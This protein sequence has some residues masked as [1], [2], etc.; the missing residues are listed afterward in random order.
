MLMHT[1]ALT[2]V[3]IWWLRSYCGIARVLAWVVW[4]LGACGA[5]ADFAVLVE[6]SFMGAL[7]C[8]VLCWTA[9]D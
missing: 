2:G 5:D 7:H 3:S 8:W 4:V 6:A 9:A 1:S